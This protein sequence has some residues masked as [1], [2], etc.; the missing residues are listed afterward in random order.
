[1]N[2]HPYSASSRHHSDAGLAS[3]QEPKQ[4]VQQE[5]P[6]VLPDIASAPA[7]APGSANSA[8]SDQRSA[9]SLGPSQRVRLSELE[10]QH[11]RDAVWVGVDE[12]LS[13]VEK[14]II[15]TSLVLLLIDALA[16]AFSHYQYKQSTEALLKV[17]DQW[18]AQ[19]EQCE[20]SYI[21]AW[22][23]LN[24]KEKLQTQKL[25]SIN[26]NLKSPRHLKHWKPVGGQGGL[27]F[28]DK[29][30][31]DRNTR[32]QA[33]TI[34][35]S[36]DRLDGIRIDYGEGV[37]SEHGQKGR[38]SRT[39]NLAE[40][41]EIVSVSLSQSFN[42]RLSYIKIQTTQGQVVEAGQVQGQLIE[43]PSLNQGKIVGFFGRSG[44]ELDQLGVIF[45]FDPIKSTQTEPQFLG[46]WPA[47]GGS[48]GNA[49]DDSDMVFQAATIQWIKIGFSDE[50]IH[51]FS[52]GY[53]H[54]AM[55]K[56]GQAGEHRTLMQL[57]V[58][59]TIASLLVSTLTEDHSPSNRVCGIALYTNLGR[60][61]TAGK[62]TQYQSV[63]PELTE[64]Q[65][66]GFYGRSGEAL[67]QLGAIYAPNS[68]LKPMVK[69][70]NQPQ[71][72]SQDE[73]AIGFDHHDLLLPQFLAERFV[74]DTEYSH[75]L[76]SPMNSPQRRALQA[77]ALIKNLN[78]PLK[79]KLWRP[80][81]GQGGVAFDD[82]SLISNQSQIHAIAISYSEDHL[83][84][85]AVDYGKGRI[86][87]YG[88]TG[89]QTQAIRLQSGEHITRVSLSKSSND[90]IGFIKIETNQGQ[91][92]QG[93]RPQGRVIQSPEVNEGRII[94]FHGRSGLEIDQLG[95]IFAFNPLKFEVLEEPF[96]AKLPA[97]G[98]NGG[99]SF[100]DSDI[101]SLKTDIA[102]MTV[103]YSNKVIDGI[104]IDYQNGVVSE[105]GGQGLQASVIQLADNERI[106]QITVSES[107]DQ[108]RISGIE[109]QT[110][111]G[112]G[113]KAGVETDRKT[114]YPSLPNGKIIG[115]HGR[116]G[117]EL[118]QLG[119]IIAPAK[120]PHTE[121]R[122]NKITSL[123]RKKN[124]L[125]A[126]RLPQQQ[127]TV[128]QL[129]E[130]CQTQNSLEIG[131][132]LA[133]NIECLESINQIHQDRAV[134]SYGG[135][136]GFAISN[137]NLNQAHLNQ[138]RQGPSN[139]IFSR[140]IPLTAML[141]MP[142]LAL[143]VKRK[144]H[145][146]KAKVSH[147]LNHP[148][149]LGET[150]RNRNKYQGR[151]SRNAYDSVYTKQANKVRNNINVHLK[152]KGV[153]GFDQ[154]KAEIKHYYQSQY[155]GHINEYR[156]R[157]LLE[158][159]HYASRRDIALVWSY[160]NKCKSGEEQEQKIRKFIKHLS[161]SGG[162]NQGRSNQVMLFFDGAEVED[163]VAPDAIDLSRVSSII[164]IDK[165]IQNKIIQE[166]YMS[167][168][169][170]DQLRAHYT[171]KT[172]LEQLKD[173]LSSTF[174]RASCENKKPE[175]NFYPKYGKMQPRV[176]EQMIEQYNA[177]D[178]G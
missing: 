152:T 73:Q 57:E 155:D 90:R 65:I 117:A 176:V 70:A 26:N 154:V 67:D 121:A 74:G 123:F 84:A 46:K 127:Q 18:Q 40:H 2:I 49:F 135:L 109:I 86:S 1:M 80:V 112:R 164:Y 131:K 6:N 33:I 66:V 14:S 36:E 55:T 170:V 77:Q 134:L 142:L 132:T 34:D 102:S 88:G 64:G 82:S 119:V 8:P 91:V 39:L 120:A 103:R 25:K 115:F 15:S 108:T 30:L 12:E 113:L 61:L 146:I 10:F 51:N 35:Y 99:V 62:Q 44:W 178:M 59:E 149:E 3:P 19:A 162:C 156:M 50:L 13:A 38:S 22:E 54:G 79:L 24:R 69:N 32:I 11:V 98:G 75:W 107:I 126:S 37:Q 71:Y 53:D 159:S 28:D 138:Y 165:K 163:P 81:G 141:V 20:A 133:Q 68:A 150:I 47:V 94:G 137:Q 139:L 41:E 157:E 168:L 171:K 92:L 31:I 136:S 27:A 174:S 148:S 97:V 125:P 95:I 105:Y 143:I 167:E 114:W 96:L 118:D 175:I 60:S 106:S 111:T 29:D 52:L 145:R 9:M 140:A 161:D 85:I 58:G 160:L 124:Q 78:T 151:I 76:M 177:V 87:R 4:P 83:D 56:H 166:M 169:D 45:A 17:C 21:K 93:G 42:D 144:R 23:A 147:Y 100:D 129:P 122:L 130:Y 7:P 116:S 173:S 128:H 110:T 48:G 43:S 104:R 101:V 158:E 72:N 172:V 16:D 63:F 5:E 153:Y 89:S